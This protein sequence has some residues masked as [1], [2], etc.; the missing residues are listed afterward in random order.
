MY[1]SRNDVMKCCIIVVLLPL[2]TLTT[3]MTRTTPFVVVLFISMIFI[4]VFDIDF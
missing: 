3:A 2:I 4:R 1:M